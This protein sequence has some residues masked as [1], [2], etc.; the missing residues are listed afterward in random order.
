M[1]TAPPPPVSDPDPS[2]F[3]CLSSQVGPCASCQR[4]TWKY[5]PGGSPL[6]Q[7]CLAPVLE[8]WGP[9]ARHTSTRP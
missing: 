1:S 6:C 7:W 4:N 8:S 3:V 9:T 2:T 5:G